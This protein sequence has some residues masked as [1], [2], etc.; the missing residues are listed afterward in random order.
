[1]IRLVLGTWVPTQPETGNMWIVREGEHASSAASLREAAV[2]ERQPSACGVRVGPPVRLHVMLGVVMH[3][4][5]Q[6]LVC[7]GTNADHD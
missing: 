1:M 4:V 7:T 5:R 3:A 2:H 6:A